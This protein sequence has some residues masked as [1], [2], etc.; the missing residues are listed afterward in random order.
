MMLDIVVYRYAFPE[1]CE[2]DVD[3]EDLQKEYD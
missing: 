2:V 3:P 1:W